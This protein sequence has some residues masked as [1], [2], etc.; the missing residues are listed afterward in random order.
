MAWYATA[1]FEE[2]DDSD[3]SAVAPDWDQEADLE[4]GDTTD[5]DSVTQNGSSTFT[6]HADAALLG[7][8]GAKV[9]I[10]ASQNTAYG[11]LTGPTDDTFIVCDFKIDPNT[12]T[13]SSGD[14]F[15]VVD[16][17]TDGGGLAWRVT[18]RYSGTSYELSATATPDGGGNAA[19][20][21]INIS[22]AAH[23]CRVIWGAASGVGNDDGY[24]Y[25]FIDG[26]LA[27]SYTGIDND[28]KETDLI[29][30][31]AVTGIDSGTSGT[32]YMDQMSWC[33]DLIAPPWII[34]DAALSGSYGMALTTGGQ[35]GTDDT[36]CVLDLSGSIKGGTAECKIDIN[37]ISMDNAD[38]F[39]FLVLDDSGAGGYPFLAAIGYNESN[40]TIYGAAYND[41]SSYDIT[42][43]H[44][45]SDG[46][47]TVRIVGAVS[48][49]A[50]NDDGWMLL[51]V[52]GE[53]LE[54]LT[55]LDNDT[56]DF[57][58]AIFA[59]NNPDTTVSG[60]IY[61][62][63]CKVSEDLMIL[64]SELGA[65]GA[66]DS[67]A[68]GEVNM[69]VTP[70]AVGAVGAVTQGTIDILKRWG[71]PFTVSPSGRIIIDTSHS[72]NVQYEETPSA[73]TQLDD[74]Y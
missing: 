43:L 30:F 32:F 68:S 10:D 9:V 4:E 22:D 53:L 7:S 15:R 13:M 49:G 74:E 23:D 11:H 3:F 16:A 31:G 62:D 24:I 25:F 61:M 12:L 44:T 18:L 51:F 41:S 55:G 45:I 2:G 72:A 1:D 64:S 21:Q 70:T 56:K 35:G 6:A 46:E 20:G 19:T 28:T 63:D 67:I 37:S 57:D 14:R 58:R 69:V 17:R 52:D 36:I 50:G 60:V 47:H 54:A 71:I 29:Y 34:D 48:T 8:Y 27:G 5:F 26:A 33:D 65:A 39:Q 40:Y 66:V 42:S 73:R 38:T 59:M